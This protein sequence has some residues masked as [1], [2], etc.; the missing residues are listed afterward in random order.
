MVGGS[1]GLGQWDVEGSVSVLESESESE[2]GYE[3]A[4]GGWCY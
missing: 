2:S 4:G 1:V 3:E